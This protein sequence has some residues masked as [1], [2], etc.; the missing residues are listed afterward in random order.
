MRATGDE[1]SSYVHQQEAKISPL[2][3]SNSPLVYLRNRSRATTESRLR[4]GRSL[5]TDKGGTV[6]ADVVLVG[7]ELATLG[8]DTL[9]LLLSRGVGI[10]NVHEKSILA[11]ADAV[12]LSDDLITDIAVLE[13]IVC[14]SICRDCGGRGIDSPSEPNTPAIAHAVAKNL[15]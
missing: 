9:Q 10:S 13:A 11:D 1:E 4:V 12:V 2:L 5:K 7:A 3:K 15:A 14:I 8:G 6:G